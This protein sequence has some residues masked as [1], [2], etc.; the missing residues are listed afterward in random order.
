MKA[1]DPELKIPRNNYHPQTYLD[2]DGE[3]VSTFSG[4]LLATLSRL[5]A[6]SAEDT[7]RSL[8]RLRRELKWSRGTTAAMLGVGDYVLRRWEDG[9]RKPSMAAR[10]LIW[11]L[12]SIFLER[13]RIEKDLYI[14][15][16]GKPK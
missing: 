4:S 8:L 16:W 11:V 6:P 15:I 5:F 7:R 10:K 2:A 9:G 1:V 14:M 13:E 3:I 12:E